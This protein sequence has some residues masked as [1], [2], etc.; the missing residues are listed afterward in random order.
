MNPW[1]EEVGGADFFF[2]L[3]LIKV[4]RRAV[5]GRRVPLSENICFVNI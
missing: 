5:M 3:R 2:L 4:Y 1:G